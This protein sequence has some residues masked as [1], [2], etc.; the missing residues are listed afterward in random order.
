MIDIVLAVECGTAADDAL[1]RWSLPADNFSGARRRSL[2]GRALLRR[3]L[4]RATGFSSACWT[5]DAE[6]SGRPIARNGRCVRVPSVSLS[7]SGGWVACAVSDAGPVGIDIEVHRLSRN[8][9]GI[10]AAAFG[11][12]ERWQ[13]AA[14]GASGFYRI[15][16]LKEAMAKASG[17]GI[18]QVADRTDRVP[19]GPKEGIWRANV[20]ATPWWLAHTMPVSGL[21]L[22]VAS[23]AALSHRM[24]LFVDGHDV[25]LEL[26]SWSA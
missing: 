11:P 7:H 22:A 26:A 4:V 15:W 9:A 2:L 6:P 21:S 1:A 17:V 18:A 3:L 16:T 13:V 25:G 5:F 23:A 8:F 20:G 14:N 10:A 12:D 19:K 24:R